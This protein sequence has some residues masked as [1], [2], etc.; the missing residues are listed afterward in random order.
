MPFSR[1]V[2][3]IASFGLLF[4]GL[5]WIYLSRTSTPNASAQELPA[6]QK[7]FLAPDFALKTLDGKAIRLSD[8]RG[9]GVILNIWASWCGPCQEEMPALQKAYAAY[10]EKGLVVLAVNETVMDDRQAAALFVAQHQ[11]TFPIL[12][13]E[14]GQ[15]GQSFRVQA[16]PS[17]YFIGP[18]GIIQDVIIGG[19]IT[20]AIFRTQ[21]EALLKEAR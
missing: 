18:D 12:L 17:S 19:P 10:Q 6:A 14:D 16:L 15:V 8:L 9:K 2:F 21:A 11:L 13:D 3:S 5:G 1:R 4:L 7:G 20:E